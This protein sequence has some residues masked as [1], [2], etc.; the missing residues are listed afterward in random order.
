VRHAH[1]AAPGQGA[2]SASL[3][4]VNLFPIA[5]GTTFVSTSRVGPLTTA[6]VTNVVPSGLYPFGA[7]GTSTVFAQT[8]PGFAVVSALPASTGPAGSLGVGGDLN[9]LVLFGGPNGTPGGDLN[10]LVIF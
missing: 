4:L 9:G 1:A 3:A 7:A 6:A 2:T 10:G 8:G 5:G